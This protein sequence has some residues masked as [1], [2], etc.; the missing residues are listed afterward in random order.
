[1]SALMI[2]VIHNC[3]AFAISGAFLLAIFVLPIVS[4]LSMV[5]SI[6][7]GFWTV[8]HV[9]PMTHLAL[10]ALLIHVIGPAFVRQK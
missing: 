6:S 8:W 10:V 5:Y 4:A 3:C 9:F 1:M 2:R 7:T